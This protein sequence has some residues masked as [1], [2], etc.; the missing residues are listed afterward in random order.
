MAREIWK[1]A[2]SF[3][4]V[5]IPVNLYSGEKPNELKFSMLDRRNMAA[6]G[7]KRFNKETGKEVAWEEIVKGYE[8]EKD[9]YVV[10]SDEDFRRANVKATQTVDIL[11]FV[12][13]S[14]IDPIYFE[15]PYYLTPGKSGEK[16]YALLR[17]VLRQTGK[18][19]IATLVIHTRQHVAAIMPHGEL[20]LLELLRFASEI[21]D[22]EELDLSETSL[23]ALGVSK[24]ELAMAE[25]LVEGMTDKWNP[26]DYR[27]DYRND[28]LAL[29]K[30]KIKAG[31]S[32]TITEP[33]PEQ[34]PARPD[35]VIDLMKLLKRSV[36]ETGKIATKSPT[37]RK[38][39]PKA[40][41]AKKITL[42]S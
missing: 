30:K 14:E 22:T 10:L 29:V 23:S 41:R 27:D 31:Q 32:L 26:E 8:Y 28:L 36:E 1:G 17:E 2:I 6:V 11:A 34:E 5:H 4:L 25:Q 16:G 21:R 9:Q 40:P 20:L 7:Y 12:Q 39:V 35:N 38:P 19:G 37:A 42:R 13:A 24:K 15:K 3:G 33:E 18:V